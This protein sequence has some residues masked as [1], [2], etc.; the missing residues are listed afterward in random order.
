MHVL[1][2][3]KT[4]HAQVHPRYQMKEKHKNISKLSEGHPLNDLIKIFQCPSISMD[5]C[6]TNAHQIRLEHACI[7]T[8]H[9][10]GIRLLNR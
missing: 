2:F 5:M 6:F 9:Q 4:V 3:H 1:A 7:C 10:L 8:T